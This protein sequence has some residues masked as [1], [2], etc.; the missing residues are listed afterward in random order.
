MRENTYQSKLIKKIKS[1]F[2]DAIVMKNDCNYIQG[3][4]DLTILHGDKW[5][6]L[7]VKQSAK[8]SHR[9]NQDYYVDK[10]NAMSYSSFIFPE[11]ED[12]VLK[13]MEAHFEMERP[14]PSNRRARVLRRQQT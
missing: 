11:N 10:M 6:T 7:E 13:E 9:P 14:Q 4:S 1:R 2:P 5:A 12:Q 3:I 8:A